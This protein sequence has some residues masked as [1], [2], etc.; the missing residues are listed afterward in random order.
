MIDPKDF[1]NSHDE[2]T[3][4]TK[5]AIWSTV[6]KSVAP[7]KSPVFFIPDVRSFAYGI[8][9]AF[10]LYFSS[11]G[12]WQ[13]VKQGMEAGQPTELKLDKAYLS[14]I[15]E[16][17]RVIPVAASSQQQSPEVSGVLTARKEQLRLLDEAI[18]GLRLET[19]AND[20]SPMKHVRLRQLYNLK[21]QVIQQMIEH[22]EIEL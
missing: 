3:R 14:A 20:L 8:A 21:L 4:R 6:E 16:L 12:V 7:T 2:P 22:G 11:I 19:G 1:Y 17:E 9:A 5:H 15:G 10:L 13:V 18:T